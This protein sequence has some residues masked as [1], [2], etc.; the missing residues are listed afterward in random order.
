[1]PRKS[2]NG[3]SRSAVMDTDRPVRQPVVVGNRRQE[4]LTVDELHQRGAGR[5]RPAHEGHVHLVPLQRLQLTLGRA[6]DQLEMD[7]RMRGAER[8][9]DLRQSAQCGRIGIANAERVELTHPRPLRHLDAPVGLG[10][11]APGRGQQ[12]RAGGGQR[13]PAARPRK[14]HDAQNSFELADLL[15]EGRLGHVQ[16]ARRAAKMQLLGHGNEIPEVAQL[17]VHR[18]LSDI[19]LG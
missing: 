11:R 1:M 5:D 8:P 4:R 18:D 12:H 17:H 13:D 6:L 9:H 7:A 3:S 19:D 15:A 14:Q 16:S 2:T 10:E